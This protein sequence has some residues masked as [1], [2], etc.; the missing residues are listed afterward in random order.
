MY[1]DMA[2]WQDCTKAAQIST[3]QHIQLL[4]GQR[5]KHKESKLNRKGTVYGGNEVGPVT[6][7]HDFVAKMFIS[8]G[9]GLV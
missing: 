7:L 8:P 2:E 4:E 3:Q 5:K 1:L 6:E 9:L